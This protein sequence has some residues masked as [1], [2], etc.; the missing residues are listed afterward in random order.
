MIRSLAPFMA[1][2]CKMGRDESNEFLASLTEEERRFL[3]VLRARR[4]S[5]TRKEKKR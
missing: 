4:M 1:H 2:V 3:W 5:K